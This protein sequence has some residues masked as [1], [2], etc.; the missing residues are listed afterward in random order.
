MERRVIDEP[1]SLLEVRD[2]EGNEKPPVIKGTAAVFYNKN[3]P[4]TEFDLSRLGMP[5]AVERIMRGAFDGPLAEG[6]D[7]YAA[8]NHE[9]SQVLSRVSAGT[10]KLKTTKRGLD[11]EAQ[12]ADTTA[13]RDAV[14]NAKAGNFGGSSFAFTVTDEKWRKDGGVNVREI[15]KIGRLVDVSPVTSPAYHGTAG[16]SARGNVELRA[17][18]D[19]WQTELREAETAEAAEKKTTE[20]DEA[21]T[22][23]EHQDR[24]NRAKLATLDI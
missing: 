22:E 2:A 5:G 12:I 16:L 21:K 19:A 10:L 13:G 17:S 24:A 11:Y 15:R 23:A 20:E 9:P 1:I 8:V 14:A 4:G 6:Q 7:T 18:F 3:D